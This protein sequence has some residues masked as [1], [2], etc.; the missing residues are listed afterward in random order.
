MS[1]LRQRMI[2]DLRIRNYAAKTI[3]SYIRYAGE[4]AKYFGKSPDQLGIEHIRDYQVF[5]V[6]TKKASW[7]VFNQTVCAL[8]FL[9]K[10]T[11]GRSEIIEHIPFP[12]QEKTLPV[13]LST[14]ELTRFFS[15]VTNLKHRTVLMT[16]Y[17]A[18][19]RLSEALGL[20]LSDIDSSRM[21]VRVRQGKGRKDRDVV[22]SPSLLTVMRDYWKV[23]RSTK[24]LFPGKHPDKPL[25]LTTIQ[26]ACARAARKA[27]IAKPVKTHTMRHCFATHLLEAG[28]D[29]RTIQLLL[30]HANLQTT[31]V[32]LHVATNTLQSTKR[33]PDLLELAAKGK[34]AS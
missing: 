12:K 26:R 14:E 20:W 31:A 13:I 22:L 34:T 15:A 30:G 6:E 29:L 3:D 16:M 27:G 10:V 7:A 28:T 23:Y 4:F 19:F 11:M 32:Y 8:R 1:K 24:W 21:V 9:Y 25:S 5:L 17:A 2:E 33:T 18:G